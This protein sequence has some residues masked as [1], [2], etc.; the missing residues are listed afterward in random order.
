MSVNPLKVTSVLVTLTLSVIDRV[1]KEIIVPEET[2]SF[3]VQPELFN[4]H[5]RLLLEISSE[6]LGKKKYLKQLREKALVDLELSNKLKK[7]T[8][9]IFSKLVNIDLKF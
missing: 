9:S 2:V 8:W 4:F 5:D 7:G 6:A 3:D 1:S